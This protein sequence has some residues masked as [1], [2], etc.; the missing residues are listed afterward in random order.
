MLLYTM[1]IML[2]GDHTKCNMDIRDFVG[3]I[4]VTYLRFLDYPQFDDEDEYEEVYITTSTETTVTNFGLF[5]PP[6]AYT[7]PPEYMQFA[8]GGAG[9]TAAFDPA[10]FSMASAASHDDILDPL[11]SAN[12]LP[13]GDEYSAYGS[14]QHAYFSGQSDIEDHHSESTGHPTGFSNLSSNGMEF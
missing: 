13:S 7:R 11:V 6:P 12:F 3:F 14:N 9:T 4:I 10:P 5:P 1:M 8:H 2:C